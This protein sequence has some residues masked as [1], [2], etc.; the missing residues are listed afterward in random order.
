M[1]V[2]KLPGMPPFDT[3]EA[4]TFL[5]QWAP[6]GPWALT[7]IIPDGVTE[8]VTFSPEKWWEAS[9]WIEKY[10]GRRNLYFHVNPVRR[11]INSKAGKEDIARMSWL[12]ID[13]DPRPGEAIEEERARALALLQNYDP[14]PTVIV[15]SGGGFQGFWKLEPSE[16]LRIDGSVAKAA[17]LEA[18]NIQLEK[19]FGGDHCHN[20]DRIMRLP[21]TVNLPTK[22]K[23][24][25]GRTPTSTQVVR[26][27]EGAEYPL[28]RFVAAVRVQSTDTGTLSGGRPKVVITGNVADV[29]VEDLRDWAAK[30]NTALKDHTLALIASGADPVDPTRYSSRSEALFRVCCDLVRAG[31][32]DEMVFAAITGSNE[33][34]VS[35]REKPNWESYAL[36]QIERAKEEAIDP[37]L[38]ELN[39]KHAVIADIGGKCRIISEV[40]DAAMK[41]YKISKQSFEDFKNRYRNRKVVI[42]RNEAGAPIEQAAGTFWI[43]H[44]MRRQ[45]ETIV[46]APGQEIDSAYNLWRGF[47]CDSLP[48]EGHRPFLEH[49]RDNLC[50]GNEAHYN[51]LIGWMARAVQCPDGPGEVALVLRGPRGTGKSFFAKEF[52]GLFGRHFLQVSDS[53]HLVGSFNAH[54]RDTV[55]LFGDEAFFA[56]DKKHESVLKT[57]VTEEHIVIEG[58]G[59]DAEAAPNYTH[60]ILASNDDWVIPAGLD[61]RRFFVLDVGA[62]RKQDHG[63]FRAI[64]AALEGGGRENLLHYLLTYSLA[65]FE[66]RVVP[67][68]LALQEQK[69]FSMSPETTW[70]F[71][72]LVD[73]RIL[74]RHG[75]WEGRAA[76]DELYDDYIHDLRDQGRNFRLSRTSLGRFIHKALPDHWPVIKQ[77]TVEMPFTNEIGMEVMVKRRGYV[78]YFPPLAEIRAHWDREF[79]GPFDWSALPEPEQTAF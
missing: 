50:A 61:E 2:K 64:R 25:K 22:K 65:D 31:V 67:N 58:K 38:R 59:V 34:A 49:L 55:V 29:G 36:R 60:L 11:P 9:E 41:R 15:D 7:S 24:A 17:E 21:G 32:P 10:Q 48:G 70:F 43:N 79:G 35:V 18:Y 13:I 77:E 26:W 14:A 1:A 4:V 5:R 37:T 54:L 28:E 46:F 73:G 69:I 71:E 78:Y 47:A 8:T 27:L 12:H 33:I 66:V 72:K 42:G 57:L 68:T 56:G 76:K 44:P 63:Y 75:K 51:Y 23:K 30:N 45:Y 53:K 6:E 3:R 74:K 16:R 20:I 62:A 39:E 52:G 19:I 40:F